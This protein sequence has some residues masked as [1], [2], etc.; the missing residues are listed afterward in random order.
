MV[1]VS[2]GFKT[3]H[4]FDQTETN[5]FSV[6]Q[7]SLRLFRIYHPAWFGIG[8]EGLYMVGAERPTLP[9]VRDKVVPPDFGVGVSASILYLVSPRL[10][11]H[12]DI[13]R[14]RGTTTNKLHVIDVS[15][16]INH[17]VGL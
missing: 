5:Y 12:A 14:W 11:V 15:L 6:T 7:K 3:L 9:Y 16:G 13:A 1:S 17:T 4:K 10:L 8:A 2:T